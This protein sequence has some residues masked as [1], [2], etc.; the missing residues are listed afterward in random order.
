MHLTKSFH[1][2]IFTNTLV[3][4]ILSTKGISKDSVTKRIS[5]INLLI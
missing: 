1:S 2:F 5:K 3:T 4:V